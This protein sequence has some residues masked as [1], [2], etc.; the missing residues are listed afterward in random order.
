MRSL[1]SAF[2]RAAHRLGLRDSMEFWAGRIRGCND[3]QRAL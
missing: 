1:L 3:A 2:K